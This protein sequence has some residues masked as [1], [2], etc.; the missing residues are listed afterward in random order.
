MLRPCRA[1]FF[2]WVVSFLLASRLVADTQKLE[3]VL[4]QLEQV[5][6]FADIS[7][8][9]DGRWVAWVGAAPGNGTAVY[10]LDWKKQ[11]AKQ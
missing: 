2:G 4:S 6:S 1:L 10:V 9:P 8:S 11:G 3:Q 7:I 5:R